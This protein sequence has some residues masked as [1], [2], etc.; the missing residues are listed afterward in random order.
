[1]AGYKFEKG[2]LIFDKEL[3]ELDFFVKRFLDILK[4]HSDYLIVSGFVSI[5]T[6]RT[7]ATED[8]D[9]L[10]PAM[11]KEAFEELFDDLIKNKFWCYQG[12]SASEAWDYAKD[13]HNI[14]FAEEGKMFPN[15][16]VVFINEKKKA[17]YYEFT[18]PNKIRI[19]DFEFKIP[20]LE[21]EILY[22][23][24]ILAGKKDKEDAFHLRTLFKDIL[25]EEKFK[26]CEEIIKTEKKEWNR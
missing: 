20:P 8:V 24:I 11:K 16:E 2:T 22:K 9:I 17:K 19:K 10:I 15:M 26:E 23:E 1:M 12:N 25:N 5:S 13:L 6:G 4:K 14:R 21:F 7:R 3:T 18:H